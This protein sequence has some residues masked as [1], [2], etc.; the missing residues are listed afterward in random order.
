MISSTR[1]LATVAITFVAIFVTIPIFLSADEYSAHVKPLLAE[2][3][4]ACHGPLRSEA[5]LRLDA[6]V[7][8]RQGSQEHAVVSLTAPHESLLLKRI[9]STEADQQMPPRGEGVALNAEEVAVLEN[10]IRAGMPAPED[11]G[12]VASPRDHWSYR[13]IERPELPAA[14][15]QAQ[16]NGPIDRWLSALQYQRGITRVGTS[17]AATWLRRVTL[18]LT[19]LPPTP[20]EIEAF[21]STATPDAR[22]RVVDR[23]LATPAHGQRWGRHWMDVWRYSD[24]DGYKEELRGSQ[25]HIWHWRDWII[26]S[27]NA[28]KPYDQMIVEMLAADET[29]PDNLDTLRA[30]GFLARNYHRSNRNIWLDATVEH[31]AKAFLGITINCA[32]CHDH[33]YDPVSQADYYN[34]RAIFEPYD[35]R[36][37]ELAGQPDVLKGGI[38]RAYDGRP[39]EPTYLYERGDDKRPRKDQ[40][41]A[42][43]VPDLFGIKFEPQPVELPVRAYQPALRPEVEANALKAAWQKVEKSRR[44]GDAKL[45]ALEAQATEPLAAAKIKQLADHT[46]ERDP[47]AAA[48]LE[49]Q[50]AEANYI[51]LRAAYAADH[52]QAEQLPP[53]SLDQLSKAA[54]MAQQQAALLNAQLAL[55][56]AEAALASAKNSDVKDAKKRETAIANAEK[57]LK[58]QQEAYAKAKDAAKQE[59]KAHQPVGTVYPKQSTGRRLALARWIVAPNNPLTARVAVNHLWMRHFSTPLVD[60]VSDLGLRMPR[61]QTQQLIDWLADDLVASGWDMKRFH[62]QVVLSETY[63]LASSVPSDWQGRQQNLTMDPENKLYWR[64]SVRRL[65]AEEIRDSL[66]AVANQL[67]CATGG[68]DISEDDGEKNHRRSVYF[69]H[70]Y[71]KQVPMLVLFDG[72]SP[73]EC[74]RRSPSIIPQQALALANSQLCRDLS[75][76]LGQRLHDQNPG[77]DY[78]THKLFLTVLNRPP[79]D[80]ELQTSLKFLASGAERKQTELSC[81]QSLVHALINHND[82]VVAR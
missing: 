42:A 34:F 56:S 28:N 36:T 78:F 51:A 24:W 11:E 80:E 15:G 1:L 27:I 25:R 7:L 20:D 65:D 19:G 48:L 30:T 17:D 33:K 31:T 18:D 4:I 76:H 40:P 13:T 71:E 79:S 81:R 41:M 49:S 74:Y 16:D 10:W 82:F 43:N 44:A 46:V 29:A 60:D 12:Y 14:S 37:E 21:S 39:S 72:A 45:K 5:G 32:R 58:T 57:S 54:G 3:C 26:E 2:K 75:R 6:A 38:P 64:G 62:R 66:L 52:A 63:A 70:A 68:P 69:R 55:T 73:N 53:A 8:I 47:V 77:A 22:E 9:T 61:P 35:V 67:D 23:L 50:A 59:I